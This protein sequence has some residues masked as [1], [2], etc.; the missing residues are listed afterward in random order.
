MKLEGTNGRNGEG[1]KEK[2]EN[3]TWKS[4]KEY[5]EERKLIKEGEKGWNRGIQWGIGNNRE[6]RE[7]KLKRAGGDHK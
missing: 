3:V 4:E 7:W 6:K 2:T 1:G 5:Q